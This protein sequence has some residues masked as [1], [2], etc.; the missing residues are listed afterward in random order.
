[1]KIG[2]FGG[3]FNPPH[4]GHINAIQTVAKKAGLGKVHII[5]AAQNPLKTP[6]EGP[7][8]EQRVELTRLAFAQYG[9]TYFVDDQE[10]KRGG[11]SYT[12]DTVMNLRK[13]YDANDLYLVVGA[14][15]FEELAQWKDY[16]K[17]L[18]EANLIV[19]TR[20]GYDMPESLEEM[21]G[22]LKPLVAEFDFNFIELNT[23][24]N[25]QFITLRDVEVS[26]SE[27]RKW[28]RSGK[29]V[30]KYLPLSV[31]S[32]IKEHK[33]YRNLGDRI[34]D[35]TKFTEFC[36]N[37]LFA[38]K[39]INVR[40]F[41]LTSMS[42]PSEYTLIASGTSTRHAAAMAEN[43]VMAVKEEYNVHPQSIEGVDEGRW[44]LVDYGSLI[45]HVFYDFVRQEYSLE[46]LW[47]EGKDMGLKDPYVGKGEP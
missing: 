10:I 32:Y 31:E 3:S 13:S 41:D 45:I 24:R 14:D 44:V 39:G 4:M 21:P 12:V 17:I 1:M 43:I 5:P 36:A 18:T 29:P 16:Q 47:R 38:K 35:Y 8:P 28:L 19:T 37:V 15:K 11:M 34:G 42:A 20:P 27:V 7:T 22:F 23:G 9:E 2:I 40:G 6:V 33:L 26:S 46:N 25:I 30:E